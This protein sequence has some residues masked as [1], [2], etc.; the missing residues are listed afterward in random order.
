MTRQ[1]A[2]D[3]ARRGIEASDLPAEI[4]REQAQ[5]VIDA[6][7]KTG[8]TPRIGFYEVPVLREG[9]LTLVPATGE[10]AEVLR[11]L[12]HDRDV[13]LLTGSI[14]NS[15]RAD[16][17]ANGEEEKEIAPAQLEEIYEDWSVAEDR[18]V[19]VIQERG[20]VVGEILLLD[21]DHKNLAC[22]M[23]LWIAGETDR[24]LGPRAIELALAHAFDTVG[25]HRVALEVYDHNPRAKHVYEKLGFVLEGTLRD[26]LRLDEGWVDLHMMS[27]LRPEW[28]A[29]R[30][31]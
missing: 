10:H 16:R 9:G 27:M 22:G 8:R 28:E 29:R 6:D 25:L 2:A 26:S 17:L 7:L 4:T 31:R 3:G 20:R 15:A 21:L 1:A 24:G 11:T 23:R 19:W 14:Q 30:D 12:M 5:A 18:A 13:M